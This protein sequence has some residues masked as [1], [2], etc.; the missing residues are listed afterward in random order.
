MAGGFLVLL[1][2]DIR[3]TSY[4]TEITQY[5]NTQSRSFGN[6]KALSLIPDLKLPM[7]PRQIDIAGEETY[8]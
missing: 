2:F 7:P 8:T 3:L 1:R 5:I 6:R 4:S